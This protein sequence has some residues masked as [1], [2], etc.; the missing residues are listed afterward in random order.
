M[1]RQRIKD[2]LVAAGTGLHVGDLTYL[3]GATGQMSEEQSRE[4][5]DK[6]TSGI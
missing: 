4:N 3:T 1:S 6:Q 2:S 5:S